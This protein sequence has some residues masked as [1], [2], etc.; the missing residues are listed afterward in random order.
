MQV[1]PRNGAVYTCLC[2]DYHGMAQVQTN[3]MKATPAIY[4]PTLYD[5]NSHLIGCHRRHSAVGD[6][7]WLARRAGLIIPPRRDL[8][9][10]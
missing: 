7:V 4:V 10:G 1:L 8:D 3:Q 2:D 5:Y 6:K 9:V